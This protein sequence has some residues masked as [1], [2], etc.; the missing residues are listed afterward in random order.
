MANTFIFYLYDREAQVGDYVFADGSCSDIIRK[1]KTVIGICIEVNPSDRKH[2]V[3]MALSDIP[4]TLAWGLQQNQ[5]TAGIVL[6]DNPS[7]SVFDIPTL[8]NKSSAS[9]GIGNLGV[10][11]ESSYRDSS[12]AGDENGFK[13]FL[14]TTA[15]G[16]IGWT[17]HDG[18]QVPWGRANTLN[19]IAH[20]NKICRDSNINVPVPE[21]FMNENRYNR[22]IQ[23]MNDFVSNNGNNANFRAYYYPAASLCHAYEPSVPKDEVFADIFK[24]GNWFFPSLGEMARMY[25]YHSKGYDIKEDAVFAKPFQEGVLTQLKNN[26][27]AAS[28]EINANEHWCIM[29]NSGTVYA[30][31]GSNG[32]CWKSQNSIVRALCEF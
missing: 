1:D 32:Y 31:A 13:V 28:T 17:E 22:L 18:K 10:V 9:G 21:D 14:P 19:I 11:N 27:Y 16:E 8:S 4:D 24:A 20:R 23:L 30:S 5:W 29:T 7:Y 12:T 2:G 6:S 25:W 26:T 15:I 3:C